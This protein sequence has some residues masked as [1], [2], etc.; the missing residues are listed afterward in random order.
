MSNKSIDAIEDVKRKKEQAKAERSKPRTRA[1]ADR[2]VQYE[3]PRTTLDDLANEVVITN[4]GHHDRQVSF[5]GKAFR[6]KFSGVDALQYVKSRPDIF[7]NG[8]DTEN[9]VLSVYRDN[10]GRL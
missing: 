4:A 6:C 2:L 5:A 1:V 10:G 7:G 8:A 3:K 9:T